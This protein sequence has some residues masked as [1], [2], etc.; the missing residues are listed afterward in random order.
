M[1]ADPKLMIAD[2]ASCAN[3]LFIL[4]LSLKQTLILNGTRP[5]DD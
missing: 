2:K 5:H 3:S 1:Q 4:D